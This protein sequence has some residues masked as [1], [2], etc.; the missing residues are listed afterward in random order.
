M[1]GR[2]LGFFLLLPALFW[3]VERPPEGEAWVTVLDVGQGLAA[4]VRTREHTL[5]YDPGPLYSAESDAG[6]RVVL[7]LIHI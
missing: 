2:L 7:S 1:P 6:Q 3:P 5:I 4:V